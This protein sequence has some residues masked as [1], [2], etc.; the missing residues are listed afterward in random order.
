MI[1]ACLLTA[2]LM[3]YLFVVVA[4]FSAPRYNNRDPRG[5]LSKQDGR[6]HRAHSAHLNSFEAFPLFATAV[7][8]ALWRQAE[9]ERI[10]YLALAFVLLRLLYGVCYMADWATPRS[11][12]WLAAL[13]CAVALFFV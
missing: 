3:P 9:V 2:G 10:G 12:V 7:L 13:G 4:K 11:L 5:W 6:S 8:F 1:V